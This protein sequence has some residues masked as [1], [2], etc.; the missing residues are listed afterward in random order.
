[1][2]TTKFLVFFVLT[3]ILLF[4]CVQPTDK[5][6]IKFNAEKNQTVSYFNSEKELQKFFISK[7]PAVVRGKVAMPATI[8]VQQCETKNDCALVSNY[9]KQWMISCKKDI[10]A[11]GN[12]PICSNNSSSKNESKENESEIPIVP[13]EAFDKRYEWE[14]RFVLGSLNPSLIQVNEDGEQ[15]IFPPEDISN[16]V[17]CL[18]IGDFIGTETGSARNDFG[19]PSSNVP[20]G[21][22]E[23]IDSNQNIPVQKF[24]FIERKKADLIVE[25]INA[26]NQVQAGTHAFPVITK[27][28]GEFKCC[29]MLY[30]TELMKETTYLGGIAVFM[31][32]QCLYQPSMGGFEPGETF[33]TGTGY[34][35]LT[36]PGNYTIKVSMY[37]QVP[38]EKHEENSVLEKNIQVT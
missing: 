10:N 38:G 37:C 15:L 29:E 27:N 21:N 19:V 34:L 7:F 20:E 14:K 2:K 17:S 26:P 11:P 23:N 36:E 18:T 30:M 5:K 16:T 31:T 8:E 1:M 33:E 35:Q 32:Q 22:N 25:S 6:F 3:L 28:I 9:F 4:G 24:C 12:Y 13:I